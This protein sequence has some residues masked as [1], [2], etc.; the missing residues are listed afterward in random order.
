MAGRALLRSFQRNL[1]SSG[2]VNELFNN[3]DMH[4]MRSVANIV[5]GISHAEK[6]D[7]G[8][9]RFMRRGPSSKSKQPSAPR[10]SA[11]PPRPR[12]SPK[13]RIYHVPSH[14]IAFSVIMSAP[15]IPISRVIPRI[16]PRRTRCD[17]LRDG[18]RRAS[19]RW[20][21]STQDAPTKRPKTAIF[22]PG[23]PTSSSYPPT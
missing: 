7:L 3:T 12:N 4:L 19:R 11:R 5:G 21:S 18:T 23:M 6:G 16:S 20:M 14:V 13:L 15:C 1:S 10:A 2:L 17:G 22:F 9:A 8:Q